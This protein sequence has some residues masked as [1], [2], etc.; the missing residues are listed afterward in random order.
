KALQD[1][2]A[3]HSFSTIESAQAFAED[4][5]LQHNRRKIE[6]FH[7]LSAEQMSQ[8]L[9]APF[10]SPDLVASRAEVPLATCNSTPL[11]WL[12][13][14]LIEEIGEKGI[15]PTAKGNLPRALCR[16]LAEAYQ[17]DFRQDDDV[18]RS[19]VSTETDFIELHIAHVVARL[20]GFVRKY[21]G[22]IIG[23]QKCRQRIRKN[24]GTGL[25][26]APLHTYV[27]KFN[28]AYWDSYPEVPMVQQ[29]FLF[30]LYLLTRYG[31][32]ERSI[33]FYVDA[34]LNAFPVLANEIADES[35]YAETPEKALKRLY[36]YR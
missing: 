11:G 23:S 31:D 3:Q 16:G 29:S 9:Y 27:R 1:A 35:P 22:R 15:K 26:P 4:F 6:E 5:L 18:W 12:F 28:W 30:T 24:D 7:G 36:T 13:L 20:A 19:P 10:D 32:E 8:M 14:S 21:K 17:S 34:F 2:M 25:D 33:E